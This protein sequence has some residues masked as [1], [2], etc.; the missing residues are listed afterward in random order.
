MMH[1][2]NALVARNG[3]REEAPEAARLVQLDYARQALMTA[4]SLPEVKKIRDIAA[5]LQHLAQQER[6]TLDIQNAAAEI[7]LYAEHKGGVLLREMQKATGTQGQIRGRTHGSGGV[8]VEPPEP[9]APTLAAMGITKTQSHRWQTIATLP[10]ETLAAHV[11]QRKAA[12]QELT[13]AGVYT[14]AQTTQKA[15][16][17][18]T[19]VQA[20]QGPFPDDLVQL[21]QGDFATYAASIPEASADL[22][23]TDPPYGAT[24]VSALEDLGALAARVLKPGGSF[25][26]MYGQAYLR[27]AMAILDTYLTYKWVFAYRLHGY[28]QAVW[29]SNV[30]NHWKPVL[31]F[32]QGTYT[33]PMQGDVLQSADEP[34]KRF[35]V[36][37]QAEDTFVQLVK[38][39]S[40]PGDLVLDPLCGGGTT[41]AA[42]V[43]MRRRFLGI[44][45][46][47]EALAITR[48]RLAALLTPELA[49]EAGAGQRTR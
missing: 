39:F 5:A 35:H 48:A 13:S 24:F 17:R 45:V 41:G 1:S 40:T 31:W 44:D 25:L 6:C 26:M 32:V 33:G 28:G 38:R 11:H 2:M 42:A 8:I 23:L 49:T 15:A 22:I 27:E 9:E 37:G 36:W 46:D 14:L 10:V 4:K 29:A 20:E 3:N 7:K 43:M 34:D 19:K 12:R 18:Q 30:Q 47:P 16:A 21:W